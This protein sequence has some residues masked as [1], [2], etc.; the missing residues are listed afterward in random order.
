MEGID[1]TDV[2]QESK[3]YV[4]PINLAAERAVLSGLC[5]FGQEIYTDISEIINVDCFTNNNNQILYKCID[6]VLI[7]S[8]TIDIPSVIAKA[9]ILG[10]G[11]ILK[12]KQNADYI[13]SLFKFNI[14]KENATNNSRV[15]RKLEIARK[16]QRISKEIYI[17]LSAVNGSETIDGIISKLEKPIFDYTVGLSSES[18]DKT[19]LI[20]DGIDEYLK[21]LE[22]NE[23]DIM[24]IPSPWPIYNEAIGGGRRRGGVYLTAARPKVGKAQP[25]DSTVYTPRGPK[26]MG[27]L[28]IGDEVCGVD[29]SINKVLNIADW[30]PL[31][32]YRVSFNDGTFTY[33]NDRHEWTIKSNKSK[34]WKTVELKSILNDLMLADRP[35]WSV[36]LSECQFYDNAKQV[37]HPYVLGVLLGDGCLQKSCVLTNTSQELLQ[38]VEK[39]LPDGYYLSNNKLDDSSIQY[40]ITQGRTGIE[41]PFLAELRRL[42]LFGTNSYDKFIPLDYIHCPISDRWQL[43]SGLI[44]TDGSISRTNGVIEYS[45]CSQELANN[46]QAVVMSLGGICRI[47]KRTT[48]CQTGA[49]VLSHRLHISFTN[50]DKLDLI[51]EKKARLKNRTKGNLERKIVSVEYVGQEKMRCITTSAQNGLYL[52]DNFIVTH[53]SSFAIN[54]AIHVA[55]LGIP[56]L[57]LDTEMSK[58]SQLP[59]ILACMSTQSMKSIESGKFADT[60]FHKNQIYESAN[61]IKK[62]PLYHRAIAGKDFSEI[63]SII[64][65]WVIQDVG[66]E[67]GVTKDCLVIYDYFKLMN[68][69]D[70]DN[71]KEHQALGYQIQQLSD[72]CGIYDF[73]CS[74]YVQMNRDGITKD[75]TDILSQSDRLLWLCTSLALLKRKTPAEI[76]TS[77]PEFGNMKLMVTQEQRFGPGLDEGDW[78][79]MSFDKEKC[80]IK[81]LNTNNNTV[82]TA[83]GG[84]KHITAEEDIGTIEEDGFSDDD[85]DKFQSGYRDDSVRK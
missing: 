45:T 7:D 57:Y 52:T 64:R 66:M 82:Q 13:S 35:K 85:F 31:A 50:F 47:A 9:T 22:E 37:I 83:K 41:S 53:N 51:K 75:T 38:K 39:L 5:K 23:Q 69:N 29:G 77:G 12:D 42:C 43:L 72:M 14:S 70:L 28:N 4:Q 3:Q 59:R 30:S 25:L 55:K 73:P 44:D 63:I 15:I 79:N 84:F 76:M 71:M 1:V 34:K 6:S 81:E 2:A 24:G 60:E 10:F 20:G 68:T 40:R 48:K 19:E 27:D 56:V 8:G 36:Q 16:C 46:I 74:S 11:D 17:E 18:G 49:S 54:D 67:N 32:S 78:I 33:C 61:R 21:F 62:I 80:Q 26:R 65:R 58:K